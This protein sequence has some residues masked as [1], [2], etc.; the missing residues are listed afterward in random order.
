MR[1]ISHEIRTP[2][3]TISMG[4]SYA[5]STLLERKGAFG[6]DGQ[7]G[8][9]EIC[10]ILNDIEESCTVAVCT[11]NNILAYDKLESGEMKLEK[12][13]AP[14]CPFIKSTLKPFEVQVYTLLRQWYMYGMVWYVCESVKWSSVSL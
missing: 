11:L 8:I 7:E 2:L 9:L 10:S 6:D 5:K 13:I 4:T 1:Y 14:V 12:Q 3:N